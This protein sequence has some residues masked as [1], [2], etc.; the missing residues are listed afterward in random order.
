MRRN[1]KKSEPI[2]SLNNLVKF[3]T[4]IA[5]PFFGGMYV[6]NAIDS[7][8]LSNVTKQNVEE[9]IRMNNEYNAKIQELREQK[10]ELMYKLN[11][12]HK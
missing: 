6:Q 1:G 4:Y 3:G 2:F 7:Y 12:Q 9:I 10:I 5:A 11:T 8:K